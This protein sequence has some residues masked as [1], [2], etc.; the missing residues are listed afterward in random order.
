MWG[1]VEFFVHVNEWQHLTMELSIMDPVYKKTV[2]SH[3]KDVID[4]ELMNKVTHF[5]AYDM[6]RMDLV[7]F[8]HFNYLFLFL[9]V[10]PIDPFPRYGNHLQHYCAERNRFWIAFSNPWPS[11]A[12]ADCSKFQTNQHLDDCESFRNQR[13]ILFKKNGSN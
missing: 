2:K 11:Q 12:L 5:E 1:T 7:D 8:D 13:R 6:N 3:A 10:S 4:L 9:I